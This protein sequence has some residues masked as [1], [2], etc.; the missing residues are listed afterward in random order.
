MWNPLQINLFFDQT[1]YDKIVVGYDFGTNMDHKWRIVLENDWITFNRSW[2]DDPVYKLQFRQTNKN[3]IITD[4]F[5]THNTE[6]ESERSSFRELNNFHLLMV[7]SLLQSHIFNTHDLIYSILSNQYFLQESQLDLNSTHGINHWRKVEKIGKFLSERNGADL[8]VV[9][10]FAY[11]HDWARLNDDDDPEHGHRAATKIENLKEIL[12]LSPSQ[13]EQLKFAIYHH[14]NRFAESD[15]ITIQTC[16]DSDR[17]DLWRVGYTPDPQYLYT[18]AAKS[19]EAL[20]Y[21]QSL[22]N[23]F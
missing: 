23:L 20:E 22:N 13:F 12:E 8:A 14:S 18:S 3:Y 7:G 6:E 9:T 17:L 1:E 15:D 11:L 5:T 21:S 2:T 19:P 4:A 10:A 16:W